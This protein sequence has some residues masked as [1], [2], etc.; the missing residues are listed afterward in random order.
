[1]KE[2]AQLNKDGY[3]VGVTTADPSPLE[4]GVF[5]LPAG[6]VDA[7]FPVIP[8]G[9]MAKWN[10]EWIYE[11]IPE[12]EPDPETEAPEQPTLVIYTAEI[13]RRLDEFA[14]TRNYDGILSATTYVTDP[15]PKFSAEAQYCVTKRGETWAKGYEIMND[16]LSGNRP[17]P[18]FEELA[19]ELPVL[20]WPQ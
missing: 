10:G 1:M 18:T 16:V 19:D 20:E 11:D 13:Q 7:P 3:F 2:V 5:L 8:E 9:K 15:N 4:P 14:R 17:L 12:P 6:A